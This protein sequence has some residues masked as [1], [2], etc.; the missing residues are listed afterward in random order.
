MKGHVSKLEWLF[1]YAKVAHGL[2]QHY[3][4]E[5]QESLYGWKKKSLAPTITAG[6][7]PCFLQKNPFYASPLPTLNGAMVRDSLL[8]ILIWP[9]SRS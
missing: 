8:G 1:R 6:T 2:A 3:I 5:P 9:N 7:R 4:Y